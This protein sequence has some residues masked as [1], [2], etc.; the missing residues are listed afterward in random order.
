MADLVYEAEIIAKW[1]QMRPDDNM[2]AMGSLFENDS[3]RVA[4]QIAFEAGRDW[5]SKN[6][7]EDVDQSSGY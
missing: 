2:R 1:K 3:L 7:G 4:L 6:T 5:Q